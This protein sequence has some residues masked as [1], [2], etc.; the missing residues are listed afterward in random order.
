MLQAGRELL[1]TL[2]SLFRGAGCDEDTNQE[3]TGAAPDE[4][5]RRDPLATMNDLDR[6]LEANNILQGEQAVNMRSAGPLS[7]EQEASFLP[8]DWN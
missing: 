7:S 4:H 5:E 1:A 2:P 6:A 8:Q 3:T